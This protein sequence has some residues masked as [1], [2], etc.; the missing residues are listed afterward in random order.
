MGNSHDADL[1]WGII[2]ADIE[3]EQPDAYGEEWEDLPDFLDHAYSGDASEGWGGMV[4]FLKGTRAYAW[5]GGIKKVDL[6]PLMTEVE[7]FSESD[8]FEQAVE[9]CDRHD[10]DW[11][12]AGWLL[13]ASRG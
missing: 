4:L 11:A 5:E 12:Q 10:L 2:V 1:V 13:I 7:A 8:R 6:D 9:W 3:E